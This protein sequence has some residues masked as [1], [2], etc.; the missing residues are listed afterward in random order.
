MY[1]TPGLADSVEDTNESSATAQTR[2]T[3]KQFRAKTTQPTCCTVHHPINT[4]LELLK[5]QLTQGTQ[6]RPGLA[7]GLLISATLSCLPCSAAH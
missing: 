6:R 5:E 1:V 7:A 3:L 2:Q 4:S